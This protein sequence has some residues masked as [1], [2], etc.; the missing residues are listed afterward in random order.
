MKETEDD[1]N[2]C[3]D[4]ICSLG[5]KLLKCPYYLKQST[6]SIPI[7]ITM[8]FFRDIEQ[9]I[10]KLVQHDKRLNNQSTPERTKLETSHSLI[11]KYTTKLQ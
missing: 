1:I 2:K 9:T 4:I 8:T 7:K 11:S 6:E 5:K 10:L 3:K